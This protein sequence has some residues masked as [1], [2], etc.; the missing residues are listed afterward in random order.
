MNH[1]Y[2]NVISML[3]PKY[4]QNSLRIASLPLVGLVYMYN[5]V[6]VPK[7]GTVCLYSQILHRK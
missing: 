4:N 2:V 6:L 1:P 3:Q 5:I 7:R